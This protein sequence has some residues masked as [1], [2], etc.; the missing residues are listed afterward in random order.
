MNGTDVPHRPKQTKNPG[1][2][3][4]K[5]PAK[6]SKKESEAKDDSTIVR[7]PQLMF[8]TGFLAEVYKERPV[9]DQN[10]RI[11]TRFPPEPNVS[12][13]YQQYSGNLIGLTGARGFSTLDTARLS[14]STLALHAFTGV[15]ARFVL[16][17]PILQ[18]KRSSTLIR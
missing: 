13:I 4:A 6:Q 8:K 1:K 7:D 18:A 17:I 12:G 5:Q 15:I 14:R 10:P 11:Q 9:S 2:Q 3:P 16:M